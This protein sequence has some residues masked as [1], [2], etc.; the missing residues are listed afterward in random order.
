MKKS[1]FYIIK[2]QFFEEMNEP[3]LKGNK[4]ENRPHYYCFEDE[5][6]GIYWMIPL[7]SKIEKYRKIM[8]KRE[9]KGKSC[10]ILHILRLDDKRESANYA[11]TECQFRYCGTA[12]PFLTVRSTAR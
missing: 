12:I 7:S 9:I 10:D 1:G 4:K 5:D 11:Q 8:E 2:E 3:Y 6:T